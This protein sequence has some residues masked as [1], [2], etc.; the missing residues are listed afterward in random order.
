[1]AML[2][3][4]AGTA[5]LSGAMRRSWVKEKNEMAMKK[6]ERGKPAG[7]LAASAHPGCRHQS[8][9]RQP[10]AL[11][12]PA[13]DPHFA[14]GNW[15]ALHVDQVIDRRIAKSEDIERFDHSF[16]SACERESR[17]RI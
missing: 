9:A 2:A 17:M 1:M 12:I 15:I 4:L 8:R 13:T 11:A 14:V 7:V 3:A 10:P 5:K 16:G 6:M